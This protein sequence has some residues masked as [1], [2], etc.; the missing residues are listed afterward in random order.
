MEG[1]VGVPALRVRACNKA[2][3]RADGEYVL[4]WMIAARRAEWNFAL[5]R[6]VEH[7]VRLGK[8][9]VV[10]KA[11][12]RR[13]RPADAGAAQRAHRRRAWREHGITADRVIARNARMSEGS[14]ALWEY[15]RSLIEAAVA[16]GHLA[17]A[18]T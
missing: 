10:L 18:R 14:E 15:A 3:L 8:P 11:L 13:P 6:A 2:P 7:A 9:L 1:L 4:Y 17:P 5:Q 12:R 16:K